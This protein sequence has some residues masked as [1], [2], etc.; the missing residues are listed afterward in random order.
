MHRD[1]LKKHMKMHEKHVEK[2]E[3]FISTPTIIYFRTHKKYNL[4][5]HM[6]KKNQSHLNQHEVKLEKEKNENIV[7]EQEVELNVAKS[8]SPTTEL[9]EE[10]IEVLKRMKNK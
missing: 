3:E 2:G 9:L 7:N 10:S 1:H 6:K 8:P 4:D 5:T